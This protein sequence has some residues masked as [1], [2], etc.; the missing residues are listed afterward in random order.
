MKNANFKK[1]YETE[2]VFDKTD[3]VELIESPSKNIG[4][5]FYD[6]RQLEELL[7]HDTNGNLA[8]YLEENNYKL[9]YHGTNEANKHI[10]VIGNGTN[11]IKFLTTADYFRV[12]FKVE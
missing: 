11:E 1:T 3:F 2:T 5:E 4:V 8:S 7:N 9:T 12:Y 10:F 6:R